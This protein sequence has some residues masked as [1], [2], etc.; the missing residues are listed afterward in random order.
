[1][2]ARRSVEKHVAIA[3]AS[4][5]Q[6]FAARAEVLGRAAFYLVFLVIFSR[7]W[8][9]LPAGSGVEDPRALLWYL[10]VTEWV[11]I[12]IPSVQLD[13][14]RDV[15]DGDVAT[16]LPRPVSYVGA[17]VSEAVGAL[18]A[19]LVTLGAVGVPAAWL[20][21]GGLPA[22]ARGLPWALVVGPLAAV[23]GVVAHTAIGLCAVWLHD[24]TA[25]TMVWQKAA[26]VLGGLVLPLTLYPA[27]LR[28]IAEA[29]PFAPFLFGPGSTALG[30]DPAALLRTV[31]L[32]LAWGTAAA[33]VAAWLHR[34]GLRV[35]DV[36][37]G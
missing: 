7:V 18:F 29:S 20:L 17:R 36:H 26:F 28:T 13:F 5:R 31:L 35:L 32:L 21:A 19:R 8:R 6:A 37:G 2:S 34:R 1:V 16:L 9:A 12:S 23:F 25:V 11:L 33:L 4:A 10:A 15:R 30:H 22:D 3:V 24:V 27:W 14:E